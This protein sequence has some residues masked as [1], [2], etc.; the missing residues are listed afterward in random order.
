[1]RKAQLTAALRAAPPWLGFTRSLGVHAIK[2]TASSARTA[3]PPPG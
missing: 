2:R 3:W 1:V